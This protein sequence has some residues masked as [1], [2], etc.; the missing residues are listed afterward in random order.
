MEHRLS[1]DSLIAPWTSDLG[2]R[3]FWKIERF[4]FRVL[5]GLAIVVCLLSP[6]QVEG[7]N[8]FQ[9]G[10]DRKWSRWQDIP[11]TASPPVR[12]VNHLGHERATEGH[13]YYEART[14]PYIRSLIGNINSNHVKNIL[15]NIQ[16]AYRVHPSLKQGRLET[17]LKEIEYTLHRLVN[18]PKALALSATVASLMD[19]PKLPIKFYQK[20]I[21]M[22][23]KRAITHAQFGNFL[24]GVGEMEEG[25]N[26]LK[27]AIKI[28]P[29][30]KVAYGWLAW[31]YE[32]DGN[33]EL[34]EE[35]IKQA[36][37]KGFRGKLP[38]LPSPKK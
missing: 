13:D 35:Y 20:A 3:Q 2:A 29:K 19:Q 15:P 24:V 1:Q 4:T 32:K 6:T 8:S 22:Y 25:I 21:Y 12:R 9:L 34:T 16:M 5:A 36:R 7:G 17:A 14:N 28:D 38:K 18:H 31:A 10:Q 27:V 33:V 30:L 37:A 23:P 26:R 11:Y